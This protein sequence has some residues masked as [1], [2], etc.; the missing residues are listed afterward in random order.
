[1][2]NWFNKHFGGLAV[3]N[4]TSQTVITTT[5]NS[6]ISSITIPSGSAID[7]TKLQPGML[8]SNPIPSYSSYSSAR[9]YR[10][11]LISY[12]ENDPKDFA[13]V[14]LEIL[15]RNPEVMKEIQKKMD[16]ECVRSDIRETI[17]SDDSQDPT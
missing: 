2:S 6:S 4:P 16:E 8:W 10:N 3:P 12:I 9:S 15:R 1:M 17:E 7:T 11:Q 5:G 13:E 14:L